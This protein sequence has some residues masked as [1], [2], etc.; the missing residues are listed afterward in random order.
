[1]DGLYFTFVFKQF[2]I[3]KVLNLEF[4]GLRLSP[5]IVKFLSRNCQKIPFDDKL[6]W[7]Q[8]MACCH[9][10]TSH[11]LSQ[12]WLRSV[13]PYV[14]T[15]PQWIN[16]QI[17]PEPADRLTPFYANTVMHGLHGCFLCIWK[18]NLKGLNIVPNYRIL[19]KEAN[20]PLWHWLISS[21]THF[22]SYDSSLM[23]LSH[24]FRHYERRTT[25]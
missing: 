16:F 24:A 9:Q 14:I 20:F 2:V 18:S 25:C 23:S 12:C 21:T 17:H 5:L 1:M 11:C 19:W 10:A 3:K 4:Y 13:S 8:V 6:T 22:L 7:V 15:W